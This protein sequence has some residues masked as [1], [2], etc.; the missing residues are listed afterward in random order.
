M[1]KKEIFIPTNVLEKSLE[2]NQFALL[3]FFVELFGLES[4][5][6]ILDLLSQN[7]DNDDFNE[8]NEVIFNQL[9]D[10]FPYF[11]N[12]ERSQIESIIIEMH[13]KSNEIVEQVMRISYPGMDHELGL[14]N[15][16][17]V[18][19]INIAKR[20]HKMMSN[21]SSTERYKYELLRQDVL[22]LMLMELSKY[23][24]TVPNSENLHC[25][26]EIFEKELY[27]G[28]VGD[29]QPKELFSIHSDA[30]NQCVGTFLSFAEAE[31]FVNKNCQFGSV[32]IKSHKWR[33]R[34]V[35]SIGDVLTN[36][37][38]KSD[39][40]IIRK[41]IYN[42]SN[43]TSPRPKIR[44]GLDSDLF[45]TTGFMFVVANGE[46]QHMIN[47]LIIL[48]RNYYPQ[49]TFVEKNKVRKGRGQSDKVSFLRF[50]AY[51]GDEESPI[52]VMVME[53]DNYMNYRFELE[54]AHELFTLRKSAVSAKVLFPQAVF[55]YD[56]EEVDKQRKLENKL[57]KE[58]LLRQGRTTT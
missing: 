26:Q 33:M 14:L 13:R 16:T 23:I 28:K 44:I 12:L 8:A 5:R 17:G 38:T 24:H 45:D 52:E 41:M 27:Q 3:R 22:A 21:G 55:N 1:S 34:E 29:I 32:H 48:I 47:R 11:R 25:L 19:T 43:D 54:Q 53:Q 7:P 2:N 15:T 20:I 35:D 9:R 30:D 4:S 46:S 50:L 36:M 40:A 49:A 58:R 37:R 10:M 56:A 39:S 51:L 18:P 6:Q 31:T 57:I 42:S